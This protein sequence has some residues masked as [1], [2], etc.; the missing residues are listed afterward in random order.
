MGRP[1]APVDYDRLMRQRVPDLSR[2]VRS[3]SR[4][5]SAPLVVTA[6][7]DA[8]DSDSGCSDSGGGSCD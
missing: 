2:P 7:A 8:A 3:A 4:D 5:D 1:D 6:I